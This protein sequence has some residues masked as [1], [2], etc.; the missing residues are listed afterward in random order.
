MP[1][2][3]LG[4][5]PP[6]KTMRLETSEHASPTERP[7]G[8]PAIESAA[9]ESLDRWFALLLIALFA[10]HLT[11]CHWHGHWSDACWACH[12]AALSLGFGLL[13]A[14]ATLAGIGAM[15]LVVGAPLWLF[16]VLF[17]ALLVPTSVLTHVFGWA[18][19]V[20]YL[21]LQ[22]RGIAGLWWKTLLGLGLLQLCSRLATPPQRNVNAA[23]DVYASVVP[24]FDSYASY[25]L[26]L[27]IGAA[28][29][30]WVMECVLGFVQRVRPERSATTTR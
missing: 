17:G 18:A 28:L 4:I 8:T 29:V 7:D 24:W 25:W 13:L 3:R 5:S 21:L 11:T 22:G 16:D 15:C 19:S 10:L 26:S 1:R 27:S 12:V 14:N 9:R 30:F 23:F 2:I 6:D 20:R